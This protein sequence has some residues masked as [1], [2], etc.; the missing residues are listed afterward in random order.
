MAHHH[1]WDARC[2]NFPAGISG[3]QSWRVMMICT[4]SRAQEFDFGKFDLGRFQKQSLF[5]RYTCSPWV[6]PLKYD[7][8]WDDHY[9]HPTSLGSVAQRTALRIVHA[10]LQRRVSPGTPLCVSWGY[11]SSPRWSN[12][13]LDVKQG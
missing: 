10:L 6:S 11:D 3:L 9:D 5:N 2:W 4:K 7:Q 12:G 8:C 1:A 13:R